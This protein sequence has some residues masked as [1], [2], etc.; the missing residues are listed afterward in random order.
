M[1][2]VRKEARS[3]G[4]GIARLEGAMSEVRDRLHNAI[5]QQRRMETRR[6]SVPGDIAVAAE[7]RP[8]REAAEELL[9]ELKQQKELRLSIES[10]NV[11][12]ELFDRTLSFGYDAALRAFIGRETYPLWMEGGVREELYEWPTAEA[13]VEA[14]IQATAR[15]VSLARSAVWLR[16]G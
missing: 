10:D 5:E 12:I 2:R 11:R 13:C 9:D 6:P 7:F 3:S 16:S 1:A 14:M 15:Y 8:V 4:R